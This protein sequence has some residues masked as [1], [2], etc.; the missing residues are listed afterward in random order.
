[1]EAAADRGSLPARGDQAKPGALNRS[2]HSAWRT[3]FAR[4]M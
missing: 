1:V 2:R 3:L 4:L